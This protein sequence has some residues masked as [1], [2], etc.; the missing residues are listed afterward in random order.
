MLHLQEWPLLICLLCFFFRFSVV[1]FLPILLFIFFTVF[2]RL[3]VFLFTVLLIQLFFLNCFF[4]FFLFTLLFS[5]YFLFF[6]LSLSVFVFFLFICFF[7]FF[8]YRCEGAAQWTPPFTDLYFHH[9]GRSELA[10]RQGQRKVGDMLHTS[11][12]CVVESSLKI[13]LHIRQCLIN[14][15]HE[16]KYIISH[17]YCRYYLVVVFLSS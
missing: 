14:Y 4:H 15:Y 6:F 17:Y 5:V 9:D 2:F 7:F 8:R 10:S 16:K 11:S 12:C 3:P 1:F 13:S